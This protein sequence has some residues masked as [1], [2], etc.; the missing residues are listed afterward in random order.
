MKKQKMITRTLTFTNVE[1]VVFDATTMT[2]IK[3][4]YPIVGDL[5]SDKDALKAVTAVMS[6]NMKDNTSN[7]SIISAHIVGHVSK[8]FGMTEQAFYN[9]AEELPPRKVYEYDIVS[10]D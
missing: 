10:T 6:I 3:Y 9:Y 4:T 5:K 8:L 7:T 1:Y 2:G